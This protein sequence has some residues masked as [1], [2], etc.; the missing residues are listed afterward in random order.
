M[1]T[2]YDAIR[3]MNKILLGKYEIHNSDEGTLGVLECIFDVIDHGITTEYRLL[4]EE[5][6]A[7]A[8]SILN[9]NTLTPKRRAKIL[10][11][12]NDVMF[13]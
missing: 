11:G 10:L 2:A 4:N 12:K 13:L 5:D 6:T 8:E 3:E 7:K 9:D 1:I